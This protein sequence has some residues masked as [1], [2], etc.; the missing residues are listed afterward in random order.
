[1]VSNLDFDETLTLRI[2][3]KDI[4]IGEELPVQQFCRI[5]KITIK[6]NK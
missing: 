2:Y 1:M 4:R 5:Y 6:G 3:R